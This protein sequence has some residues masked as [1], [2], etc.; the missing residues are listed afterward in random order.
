M[1]EF[2]VF[3][4][5]GRLIWTSTNLSKTDTIGLVAWSH[6]DPES[7]LRIQTAIGLAL[8]GISS[9]TTANATYDGQEY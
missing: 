1:R 9:T 4:R 5:S 8:L 3:D 6:C 2:A 7:T